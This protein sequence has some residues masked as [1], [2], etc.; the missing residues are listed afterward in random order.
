MV[1]KVSNRSVTENDQLGLLI[2]W[3]KYLID[4]G[5]A[6]KMYLIQSTIS[7]VLKASQG[8]L[9]FSH[10]MLLNIPLILKWKTVTCIREALMND[11]F[12][13]SNQWSINYD[14]FVGQ[15]DQT[16]KMKL[17][18]KTSG[19]FEIVH[20]H[21]NGTVTA[22]LQDGV[23]EQTNICCTILYKDPLIWLKDQF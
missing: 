4:D 14:Y 7:M 2:Y 13:K 16:T 5:L 3:L 23:T 10:D 6:T 8:A 1:G 22:F 15:Y 12:L 18:I 21:V 19:H 20:N 9:A 17:A 11:T